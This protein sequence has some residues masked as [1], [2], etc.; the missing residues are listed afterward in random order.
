[1]R[2]K[3]KEVTDKNIIESVFDEALDCNMGLSSEDK[4]YII[5]MNFAYEDNCL[6]LHSANEGKK[7]DI[8]K[9]ND[10]VCIEAHIKTEIVKAD[11]AC[12]W[13]AKYLS[14]IGFGKASFVNDNNDKK[15][16]LTLMMK[17]YSGNDSW[18]MPDES[19]SK[20]TVIK[21]V[22]DSINCKKSGI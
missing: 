19:L 6:Y 7:I 16:A 1:M 11:K 2:R 20:V 4:P 21:V 14:V 8:L 17:K 5:P 12:N 3:D 9:K 15:K 22:L 10:N 18:E 13:G